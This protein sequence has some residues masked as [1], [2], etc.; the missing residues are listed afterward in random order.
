MNKETK[1]CQNCK[2]PFTIEPED[3]AFYEKMQVP[4]PTW[5]PQC[6]LQ[7][8]LSFLNLIH[9]YHRI[10]GLCKQ[11]FITNYHPDA[12]F[13]VYC[14]QCWWSDKWDARD[15]GRD[16]DFSK[17]FFEQFR[18]LWKSVP[19]IGLAVDLDTAQNSPYNNYAGKV[20][21]SYLLSQTDEVED[22]AYG[23]YVFRSKSTYDCSLIQQ[24]D[25]CY[26]SAHIYKVSY[27]TGLRNQVYESAYCS[28]L[29]DCH[30]CTDCFASA[31]LRNKQY[32]IFNK[33]YSKEKYAEEMKKWDFGSYR[34]YMEAKKAAES[35][36]QQYPPK[37]RFDEFSVNCTGNYVHQ[38][39]NCKDC[40]EVTRGEDSRY[41]FMVRDVKD[42]YDISTWGE[43]QSCYEG[44][45]G[46]NAANIR[47]GN[48]CFEGAYD[49]EYTV[50][51]GV[52]SSNT[53][54]CVSLRSQH[55]CILNKQYSK[56]EY[57]SLVG[58]IKDEMRRV[59][60][61]D[62][63]GRKY[64]YGEFFPPEFS[65]HGYNESLAH[66]MFPRTEDEART[67][68]F[69]WT[70]EEKTEH[71]IDRDASELPDHIKDAGERILK[72]IIRCAECRR[73]F[74]IIPREL[75][76][77]K[78]RSLPLP[79]RCPLCRIKEK[80]NLWMAELKSVHGV[81]EQCGASVEYPSSLAGQKI[82]CA[83]CYQKELD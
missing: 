83:K 51:S 39:K 6:R 11:P 76:F 48:L 45:V 8:R 77:L 29:R 47:F 55:Y 71:H 7:R 30:H 59:P 69:V 23:V 52:G 1:T 46:R 68:G 78:R 20:K 36:W 63:V 27:G 10:C 56:E 19:L 50:L 5:C 57:H 3:F 28:F 58:K 17:P 21:D 31:N 41:L 32:H 75:D 81:C 67:Q 54:G 33:P 9:L 26:D 53:F 22:C 61:E 65:P 2:N 38:S 12:P 74:R 44:L 82:L 18:E 13:V 14:P 62:R 66:N 16:Y 79:R 60:F 80:L 43:A 70:K 40:Y 15:Y 34:I 49:M 35:H 25:T 42:S 72:E 64:F 37:V 73:G 4:A 24:C